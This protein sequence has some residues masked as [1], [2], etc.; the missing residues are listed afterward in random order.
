MSISWWGLQIPV[1]PSFV[2]LQVMP[3]GTEGAFAVWEGEGISPH[4][5]KCLRWTGL[6]EASDNP[7]WGHR[8]RRAE[9]P[10]KRAKCQRLEFKE[11]PQSRS[12]TTGPFPLTEDCVFRWQQNF[13]LKSALAFVILEKCH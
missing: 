10:L 13:H 6:Q 3:T 8:H 12:V 11:K 4:P 1:L 5:I 7:I 9:H 2:V